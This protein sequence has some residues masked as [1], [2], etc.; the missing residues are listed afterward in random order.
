M[1]L[2]NYDISLLF[3]ITQ[4]FLQLTHGLADALALLLYGSHQFSQRVLF[5][6]APL[7]N[8]SDVERS[9]VASG[10]FFN[11]IFA[12]TAKFFYYGR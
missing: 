10:E 5:F 1:R 9:L 7:L 12:P 6:L 3:Y 8:P 11:S 4:Q 2:E